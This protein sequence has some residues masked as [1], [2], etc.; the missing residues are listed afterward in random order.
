MTLQPLIGAGV[1]LLVIGVLMG[2]LERI[3]PSLPRAPIFH[4]SR[5]TDLGY[6]ALTVLV[7][8]H[9]TRGVV[10]LGIAAT[11]VAL[12]PPGAAKEYVEFMRE[13]SVIARQPMGLQILEVLLLT[14]FIGYWTHRAFHRGRLWRFHAVHHSAPSLDWLASTRVHP[15]NEALNRLAMA[16]PIVFV[17][18]DPTALAAATPLFGLFA[19]FLHAN[20]RFD[21][22]PLKYVVATPF[23]H[24]WHH[25]SE[26]E[27]RDKNFAGLFPLW[28]AVFGTLYLPRGVHATKFG[29]SDDEGVPT[30]LPAQLVWPFRRQVSGG[31]TRS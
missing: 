25:T 29:V 26:A 18:F 16:F 21:F 10:F 20:V 30:S 2:T 24:R 1:G 5:L 31:A 7:T 23:F 27:G 11:A 14:D 15:V 17:G 3:F 9:L 4:Q 22:G 12:A 19:I 6:F 8:K 28:D 13:T